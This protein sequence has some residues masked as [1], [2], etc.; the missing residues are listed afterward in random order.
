MRLTMILVLLFAGVA[1]G[2]PN[3]PGPTESDVTTIWS[4]QAIT[5]TLITSSNF[6]VV[7]RDQSIMVDVDLRNIDPGG[8][9]T[10]NVTPIW[11]RAGGNACGYPTDEQEAP[12]SLSWDATKRAAFTWEIT[13]PRGA[14]RL[15][16]QIVTSDPNTAHVSMY[17]VGW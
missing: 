4:N 12:Q 17:T 3:N 7:G 9:V 8:G 2:G 13:P 11:E 10:V 15:Y 6:H 5:T 14:A 16:F 1:L